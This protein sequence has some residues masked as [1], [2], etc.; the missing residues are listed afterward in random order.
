MRKSDSRFHLAVLYRHFVLRIESRRS[1]R[2]VPVV[3]SD[4]IEY[5]ATLAGNGMLL[6]RH[7]LRRI[8][9]QLGVTSSTG[10]VLHVPIGAVQLLRL[11]LIAPYQ[12]PFRLRARSENKNDG[13]NCKL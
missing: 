10:V 1:A 11:K 9:L 12:L 5:Q 6:Y 7:V 2:P 13:N 3:L 4:C 8:V